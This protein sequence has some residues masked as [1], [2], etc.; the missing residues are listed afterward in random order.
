[1]LFIMYRSLRPRP[2]RRERTVYGDGN[3]LGQFVSICPHK[4]WYSAKFVEFQIL[5]TEWRLGNVG[6]NDLEV[7]LVCLGDGLNGCG[8]WIPLPKSMST[9]YAPA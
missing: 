3:A 8:A 6:I 9:G 1:M 5:D 2:R 7:K 4:G